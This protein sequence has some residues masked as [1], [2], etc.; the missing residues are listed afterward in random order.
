MTS[1]PE[2]VGSAM[3][4]AIRLTCMVSVFGNERT[5]GSRTMLRAS[6]PLQYIFRRWLRSSELRL[7][8]FSRMVYFLVWFIWVFP[9][10]LVCRMVLLFWTCF[11]PFDQMGRGKVNS[12]FK[13]SL[14]RWFEGCESSKKIL[15]L[16]VRMTVC[17][18][19]E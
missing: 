9:C 13:R 11:D 8:I 18:W 14:L 10:E 1:D 15:G 7:N 6:V 16:C 12:L 2:R 17:V 3:E 5:L 19:K 4:R